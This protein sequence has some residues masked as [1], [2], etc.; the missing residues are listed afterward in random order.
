MADADAQSG[1]VS[2]AWNLL[3]GPPKSALGAGKDRITPV[4]GLSALSLD[5]LTSV[6]YGPEAIILVLAVAGGGALHRLPG[7]L[8]APRQPR[9]CRVIGRR[10]H[11]DR[12][13]LHRRRRRLPAVRLPQPGR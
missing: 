11:A 10:L 13:R 4:Q 9:R 1:R 8:R 2:G 5:A 6:A 12:R 7:Q 3:I